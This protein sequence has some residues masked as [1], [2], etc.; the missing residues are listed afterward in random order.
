MTSRFLSNRSICLTAL[1]SAVLLASLGLDATLA[2]DPAAAQSNP[3]AAELFRNA[4]ALQNRGLYDLAADEWADLLKRFADDPLA[5][6]ARNYHGVCLFQLK[7]YDAAAG[8]FERVLRDDPQ[9]EAQEEVYANLGLARFNQALASGDAAA[10]ASARLRRQAIDTFTKQ[11]EQF[12][13]GPLA[14]QAHYYRGEVFYA[15][16]QL[17]G[18]IKDYEAFVDGYREHPLRPQALYGLGVTLQELGEHEAADRALDRFLADYPRHELNTEVVLRRGE[19]LLALGKPGEAERQFVKAAAV[20]G[21]ADADY[22]LDRQAACRY[23][24]GNYRGA[25]AVYQSLVDRFPNSKLAAAATLA[26]GKC[27]YLADDL[28]RA[29]QWLERSRNTGGDGGEASHWLARAQ[30]RAGKPADALRTASESLQGRPN[31]DVTVD[32]ELDRADALYEIA[33]RRGESIAAYAELARKHPD[34]ALAPQAAYMA[35]YAA[36]G[37]ADYAAAMQHANRFLQSYSETNFA[38]DVH[39]VAAE[40][41]LQLG[42]HADAARRYHELLETFPQNDQRDTWLVRLALSQSLAGNWP[43]VVDTLASQQGGIADDK[44]RAEAGLLLGKAHLALGKYKEAAEVL[45]R[46]EFVAADWQQADE[47]TFHLARAHQATGDEAA[48]AE[49]RKL[50]RRWPQSLLVPRAM[51]ALARMQAGRLEY[52]AARETLDTLLQ[53]YPQHAAAAP[54][55]LLRATLRE[56]LGIYAGGIEDVDAFLN[57]EPSREAKSDALYIRGLCQAALGQHAEARTAFQSILN[58]DPKYKSADRVMYELAWETENSDAG[59]ATAVFRQLAERFP[60]SP[61][62]AECWYRVGEAQSNAGDAQAAVASFALAESKTGDADLREKAIHKLAW[63]HFQTGDYV[64]ADAQFQRQLDDFPDGELATD[65]RLM[66]AESKFKRENYKDALAVFTSALDGEGTNQSLQAISLL[67]AGQAAGQLQQWEQSLKLLDRCA[68]E[69]ADAEFID[70]VRYEKG[71]A[72]YNLSRMDEAGKLFEEVA[73]RDR[74][75]LGARARFM[76]GEVQ[77]AKKAY[78]DAVRTFFKVAYGYGNEKAP[79]PF[80][81]WQSEA[82]FEAAR[83]LEQTG[84]TTSAQRLYRELV[85]RFPESEKAAL[86]RNEL[87]KSN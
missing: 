24:A 48:A 34:H 79:E 3:Q 33:D 87:Q 9:F 81:H 18:A 63:S 71:W 27:L 65:A 35:A 76:A 68:A 75:V 51:L 86:A 37:E 84:R 45:S 38:P 26:A 15:E 16:H 14:P 60:E 28:T 67:H 23:A 62:A 56:K 2:Q 22:A 21:F 4:V 19:V 66:I 20:D 10:D 72:L 78:D 6:R 25:A 5:T 50:I 58:D 11:L 52:D 44:L 59:D 7:R 70:D 77:F 55:Y 13:D 46:L 83:C 64:R 12:P 36:L 41:Q 17:V 30:L 57:T 85:E 47:V 54:A 53:K 80:H 49:Y 61:L 8:Q 29:T 74:F 69:H 42:E 31:A 43:A 82:M 1:A 32:L 40:S 73:G 39:Y